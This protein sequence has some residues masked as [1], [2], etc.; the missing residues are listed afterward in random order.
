MTRRPEVTVLPHNILMNVYKDDLVKY[1]NNVITT[2]SLLKLKEK[3]ETW[4]Y[5][6]PC[7][8]VETRTPNCPINQNRRLHILAFL[9]RAKTSNSYIN[10]VGNN[11]NI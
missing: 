5:V 4:L 10:A 9:S 2:I 3:K 8:N 11:I 1:I 7:R 6:T